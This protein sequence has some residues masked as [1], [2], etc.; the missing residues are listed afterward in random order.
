MKKLILIFLV[1]FY[2]QGNAQQFEAGLKAGVNVSNFMGGDFGE[3]KNKALL[4]LH[5]GGFLRFHLGSSFALQPELIFSNQGAQLEEG[6]ETYDARIAYVN[7]PLMLQWHGGS[8]FYAEAG[9]QLG[10]KVSEEIDNQSVEDFAK[11]TD[12]ALGLGL[13]YQT[14]S[15]FGLGARYNI[16]VSKV[17]D[18]DP[19]DI[20]PD[21]TNGVLQVSIFYSFM[22]NRK[23]P[24]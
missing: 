8:G 14:K 12:I 7:I 4:G 9:P 13:G 20:D 2:H 10:F 22:P 1:L 6:S 15:G 24:R 17:G 5:A 16:G 18:F 19:G 23:Q 21:F 11:S 3:I